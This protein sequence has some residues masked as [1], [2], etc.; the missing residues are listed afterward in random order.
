M[1]IL[2]FSGR[3]RQ[4][5]LW[6]KAFRSSAEGQNCVE[7]AGLSEGGRA[8]RDSKNPVGPVLV[9]TADEWAAFLDGAKRGAFDS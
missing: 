8:V 5:L 6:R 9:C 2:D 7:V 4:E 1:G 3:L